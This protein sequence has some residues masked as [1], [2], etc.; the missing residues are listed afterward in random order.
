MAWLDVEHAA[1]HVGY[2]GALSADPGARLK[3]RRAFLAW[4]TRTGVPCGHRGNK[5]VYQPGDLDRALGG[6]HLT[7]GRQLKVVNG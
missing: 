4:A 6:A 5:P 1:D 7:T 3:A 2:A